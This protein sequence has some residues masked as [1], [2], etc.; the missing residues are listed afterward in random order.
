MLNVWPDPLVDYNRS[1]AVLFIL[2]LC[3][4]QMKCF[5]LKKQIISNTSIRQSI[6][7]LNYCASYIPECCNY[8]EIIELLKLKKHALKLLCI[9]L[10]P[11]FHFFIIRTIAKHSLHCPLISLTNHEK[12]GVTNHL[13]G[14]R[15]SLVCTKTP[16]F[17]LSL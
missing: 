9:S 8:N 15:L 10:N 11:H 4:H 13:I 2:F 14:G 5:A 6:Q 7:F 1:I 17:L 12:R 3:L 16:L